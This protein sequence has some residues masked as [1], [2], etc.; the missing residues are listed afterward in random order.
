MENQAFK[1]HVR[2]ITDLSSPNFHGKFNF[3]SIETLKA[4]HWQCETKAEQKYL[5]IKSAEGSISL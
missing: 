2:Q 3:N 4:Y 1:G 5:Y